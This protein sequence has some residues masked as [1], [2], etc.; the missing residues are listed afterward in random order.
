MTLSLSYTLKSIALEIWFS[1][2]KTC[3]IGFSSKTNW[4]QIRQTTRIA[5]LQKKSPEFKHVLLLHSH[6]KIIQSLLSNMHVVEEMQTMSITQLGQIQGIISHI[7]WQ[8]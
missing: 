7:I 8:L 4:L 5:T 3:L 2:S 6:R 1:F